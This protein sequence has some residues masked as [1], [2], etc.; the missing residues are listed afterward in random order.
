MKRLIFLLLAIPMATGCIYDIDEILLDREDVSM[1]VKGEEQFVY[2]PMTCQL[3]YNEDDNEYRVINDDLGDWFVVRCSHRPT[4]S[5][6]EIKA[7]VTWTTANDIKT[8]KGLK[9]TVR[10][11]SPD[12]LIW[13]WCK[14]E[15]MG[16]TVK[17]I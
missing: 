4:N 14:S 6:Q 11:T 17:E 1:T 2:D 12:G 3:G 15:K 10:K 7:D 5:G 9:F 13:M 16:V 8:R